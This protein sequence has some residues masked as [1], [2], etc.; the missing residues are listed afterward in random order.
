MIDHGCLENSLRRVRNENL[1]EEI[2]MLF[3]IQT[4]KYVPVPKHHIQIHY[5]PFRY[6][7]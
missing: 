1:F 2:D 7:K 6:T 5:M 4:L 3:M